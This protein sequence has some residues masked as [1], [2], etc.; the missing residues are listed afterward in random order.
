MAE[1]TRRG[2]FLAGVKDTFPL[3][4]GAAPFG[5]IFGAIAVTGG[6]S[7]A[8]AMGMSLIVFA[9]SAQFIGVQLF[10]Q[11]TP[12]LVI[13]LTTFIVNVRHALYGASLAPYVKHLSQRWLLPLAFWLTDETY[14][15]VIRRYQNDSES[16]YLHWYFLGSSVSMYIN[17][18]LW[19]L[20]GIIA[21]QQFEGLAQLG[22][23]FALALT[24]IG[25]VVPL[26]INRPMLV[27][28]VIAGVVG[29]V[30]YGL[31]NKLGLMVA[32]IAGIAAGMIAENWNLNRQDTQIKAE[33]SE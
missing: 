24:F 16:P 27:C 30:T 10:A 12:I 21:G 26:I 20:A 4:L 28:A 18:Q 32:A 6:L 8:A 5:L 13:V 15:I 29:V 17:W 19:T 14:A 9:G 23:D 1:F 25:I 22:L 3:M 11:G 2:E 31:P 33:A 7:P